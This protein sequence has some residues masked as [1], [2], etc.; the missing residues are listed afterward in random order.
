M[1]RVTGALLA[2]G[3]ILAAAPA[4]ANDLGDQGRAPR[5]ARAFDIPAQLSQSE[6]DNYRSIFADLRMRNWA[7]AAGRLDGMRSGP[8]HDLA[9]AMLYTMPGSPPVELEPLRSLLERGRHLPRPATSPGSP[10]FAARPAC[11][12][13]R[14]SNASPACPASRAAPA[15]ARS[16]ATRS[17]TG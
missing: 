14:S 13:S 2:A 11:P 8:L 1:K 9:R 17:P 3:L 12:T 7:S 6:R 4:F 5:A 10:P 15:P 16:G